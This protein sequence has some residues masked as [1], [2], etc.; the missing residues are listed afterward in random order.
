MIIARTLAHLSRVL[1]PGPRAARGFVPT[2]GALHAGHLALIEAAHGDCEQVVASIFVN[3]KQFDDPEDLARYPRAEAEDVDACRLAGVDVLF[4][5][6]ADELYPADF[7]TSIHV[8]GPALLYEGA[9]RSGH[10]DGVALVCMKLFGLVRPTVVYMGQKDAQQVAVLRQVCRD[11]NL[12]ID[13]SV[14]ATRRESD[15]LAL[16]SRNARLSPE[17]RARALGLSRALRAG[18]EAYRRGAD[19]VAPAR[20]A[21]AGLEVEYADVAVFDG[22][23]TLVVAARAGT[24]RLIDNVPLRKPALA[25]LS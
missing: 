12:P 10:F 19:P 5:P 22:E 4:L 20:A 8:A 23:P 1:G 24:T 15:G 3:P 21:L 11:L 18:L 2:M 16:S 13:I 7:A 6:S 17:E 9:H 25:G 14:V